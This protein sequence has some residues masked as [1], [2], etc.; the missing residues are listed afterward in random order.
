MISSPTQSEEE[1]KTRKTSGNWVKYENVGEIVKICCVDV[2]RKREVVTNL[3]LRARITEYAKGVLVGIKKRYIVP[4]WWRY[5]N[6][7]KKKKT[8]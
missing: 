7:S 8:L 2:S 6:L 5:R 1:C 4:R 3:N